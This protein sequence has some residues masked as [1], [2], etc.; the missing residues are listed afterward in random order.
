M[1][2]YKVQMG[3]F[4]LYEEILKKYNF[5]RQKSLGIHSIL[6]NKLISKF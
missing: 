5:F 2:Q 6:Q 4:L 1:I 3:I